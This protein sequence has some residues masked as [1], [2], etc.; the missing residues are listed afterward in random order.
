MSLDDVNLVILINDMEGAVG[1]VLVLAFVAL[2]V[3]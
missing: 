3:S 1:G 2:T